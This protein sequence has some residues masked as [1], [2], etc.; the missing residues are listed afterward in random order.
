M[1]ETG[2]APQLERIRVF[3]LDDHEIFRRGLRG[4]LAAE[5]DIDVVGEAGTMAAALHQLPRLRPDVAVLDVRLQDGDGIT[6]CREIRSTFPRTACLMVTSYHGDQALF[7]AILAGAAGYVHKQARAQ[8]LVTAVRT[9]ALGQPVLDA[10]AVQRVMDRLR[11]LMADPMS[12]LAEQER[13]VLELIG[14]GLTNR[15]IAERM[16]LSEATVKNYVSALLTK[17]GMQ[18]RS[19]AAAMAARLAHQD[20]QP[21]LT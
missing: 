14:V 17:L 15:Q 11:E 8:E 16:R 2:S 21:G 13:N 6:V 10:H 20:G 3:V 19:Q 7:S 12:A 4:T 5:P 1:D 18:R 9:V